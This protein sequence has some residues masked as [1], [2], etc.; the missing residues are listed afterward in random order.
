MKRIKITILFVYMTVNV[1]SQVNTDGVVIS[2]DSTAV[3]HPSAI[4][5]VKSDYGYKEN[6]LELADNTVRGV[7]LPQ[8]TITKSSDN[9]SYSAVQAFLKANLSPTNFTVPEGLTFYK[10][11]EFAGVYFYKNETATSNGGTWHKLRTDKNKKVDLP[12]GSIIMYMG[13]IDGYFDVETGAGI[14]GTPAEGWYICNGLNGTPPLMGKF[15]KAG[16]NNTNVANSGGTNAQQIKE[17]NIEAHTHTPKSQT[18]T[19]PHPTHSD[20]VLQLHYEKI[21]SKRG[22]KS[23]GGSTVDRREIDNGDDVIQYT[24]ESNYAVEGTTGGV[25]NGSDKAPEYTFPASNAWMEK[26]MYTNHKNNG[27]EPIDTD[28][29]L[30]NRPPY[31]VVIYIMKNKAKKNF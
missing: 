18:L 28:P 7:R 3:P 2:K 31:T 29:N 6:E 25:I 11:N 5:D 14:L 19:T 22:S 10:K 20:I 23:S 12:D 26:S 17:E 13:Q 30:E 1:F 21:I 15:I 4:L 16:T 24:T 9:V 27:G 8:L